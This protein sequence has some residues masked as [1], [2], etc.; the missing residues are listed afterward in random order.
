MMI[1]CVLKTKAAVA[2]H[3][4]NRTPFADPYVT[5]NGEHNMKTM[6]VSTLIVASTA[7]CTASN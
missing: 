4:A 1:Q 2:A 5:T 7:W 6:V 3:A